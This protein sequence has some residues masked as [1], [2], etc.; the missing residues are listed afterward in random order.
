MTSFKKNIVV[1]LCLLLIFS[2]VSAKNYVSLSGRFYVDIPEEWEKVD[3]KIVDEYLQR[4]NVGLEGFYYDAV[5]APKSNKPFYNG[6]Y[7]IITFEIKQELDENQIDSVLNEMSRIF[8]SNVKYFPAADYLTDLKSN[9]PVYDKD[10]K[11]AYVINDI[12]QKSESYKKNLLFYKFYHRGVAKF[13][14]YSPDSLFHESKPIF[15]KIVSSFSSEN[16]EEALPKEDVKIADI[17]TAKEDDSSNS[18]WIAIFIALIVVIIVV[19]KKKKKE[20]SV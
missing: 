8:G 1:T 17:E 13:Y 19:A 3:F 16:I 7:V 15:E 11:V 6:N 4:N 14:F 18:S 20:K 2:A 12:T 9:T 5:F 10:Q